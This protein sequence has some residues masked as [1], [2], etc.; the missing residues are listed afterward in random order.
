MTELAELDRPIVVVPEGGRP[1]Y[2]ASASGYCRRMLAAARLGYEPLPPRESMVRTA[3]EG[4]RHENWIIEDLEEMG[5]RFD[6]RNQPVSAVFPAFAVTG[7]VDAMTAK[8]VRMVIAE[9]KSMSRSRF[10][11]WRRKKFDAFP[12]YAAQATTY[13]QLVAET[14]EEEPEKLV[15]AVKCRDDGR[16]DV[17]ELDKPPDRW[18]DIYTRL[19]DVEI[20]ARKNIL[21]DPEC[22]PGSFERYICRWRYL[23]EEP[24]RTEVPDEIP[25]LSELAEDWRR[26]KALE[27][28]AESLIKPARDRFREVMASRNLKKLI[29]WGLS[30]SLYTSQRESFSRKELAMVMAEEGLDKDL[31]RRILDRAAKITTSEVLRI[32]DLEGAV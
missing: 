14:F 9:V 17:I 28:E 19:L 10:E 22:E 30:L 21:P 6:V 18:G 8:V 12:E 4:R 11:A 16:L 23:C 2:R 31:I 3:R 26:G 32:D 5:Y 24:A 20:A 13:W 25:D 7:H 27:E 29:A 1:E 15:F